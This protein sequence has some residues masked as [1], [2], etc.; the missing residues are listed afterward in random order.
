MRP[1]EERDANVARGIEDRGHVAAHLGALSSVVGNEILGNDRFFFSLDGH[2]LNVRH[3]A[4]FA[5]LLE[6][7]AILL[8]EGR[9]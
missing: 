9:W 4:A 7:A 3:R 8:S 1:S 6:G 5:D 2:L